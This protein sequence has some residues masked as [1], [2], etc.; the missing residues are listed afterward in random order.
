MCNILCYQAKEKV[1]QIPYEKDL[2]GKNWALCLERE[3]AL[4]KGKSFS[5]LVFK[6]GKSKMINSFK[7]EKA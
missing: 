3:K 2:K 5:L 1:I 4:P 7:K 6:K